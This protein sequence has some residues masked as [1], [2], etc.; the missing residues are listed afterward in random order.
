[1]NTFYIL[2]IEGINVSK[3]STLRFQINYVKIKQTM[4]EIMFI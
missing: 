2:H 4:G 3:S 1:M